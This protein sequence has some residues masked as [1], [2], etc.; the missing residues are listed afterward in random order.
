MPAAA[1]HL[2]EMLER[3]AGEPLGLMRLVDSEQVVQPPHALGESG[4]GED[5][6]AAQ[7]AEAVDLGEAAGA[8]EL[9]A[10]MDRAAAAAE[11]RSRD[12]PR[13]SGRARRSRKLPIARGSAR[14]ARAQ[15]GL[16]RLVITISR[17]HSVIAPDHGGVEGEVIRGLR[18]NRLISAPRNDAAPSSGS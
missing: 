8:D 18:S 13:R 2:I 14:S 9:G 12:R 5:P 7:A 6:A 10:E 17:V 1:D 15:L 3:N 4:L 11:R 16:W